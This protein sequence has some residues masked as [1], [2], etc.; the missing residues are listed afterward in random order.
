M[1]KAK[2]WTEENDRYIC[3]NYKKLTIRDMAAVIGCC[4]LT[5]SARLKALG[6]KKDDEDADKV[7]YR[8]G[9]WQKFVD[10]VRKRYRLKKA[11]KEE[12]KN[13]K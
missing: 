1:A 5:L 3:E 2:K 13:A 7:G 4:E 12:K 10:M 9:D 8:E 6:V 11:K